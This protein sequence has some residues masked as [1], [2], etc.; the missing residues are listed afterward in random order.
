[1]LEEHRHADECQTES[2]DGSE[3]EGGG[4]PAVSGSGGGGGDDDDDDDDD[5]EGE[6]GERERVP[7]EEATELMRSNQAA[8]RQ[9][10]IVSGRGIPPVDGPDEGGHIQ[11]NLELSTMSP[12]RCKECRMQQSTCSNLQILN[13]RQST[14]KP[15]L[16]S[17]K[18]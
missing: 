2:E 3:D 14:M 4:S 7:M 16:V 10:G 1:M 13:H 8:S 15:E 6:E 17:H 12:E 11:Q 9:W 5:D 18:P